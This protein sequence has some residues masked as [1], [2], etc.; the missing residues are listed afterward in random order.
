M[1]IHLWI[2]ENDYQSGFPLHETSQCSS[3]I[4]ADTTTQSSPRFSKLSDNIVNTSLK[5]VYGPPGSGKTTWLI[6][7]MKQ[8]GVPYERIAF[9]SFSRTT[10]KNIKDRLDLTKE[11]S[12]F[13]RTVHSMNFHLL[14]IKKDQVAN[15]HL[16]KFPARFSKEFLDDQKI[17]VEGEETVKSA[18]DTIDDLFYKQ[19][20]SERNQ[21]LPRNYVP[22]QYAKSSGLYL[23]FKRRYFDWLEENDYIDFT[24]M[25]EQGIA[26]EHIPPVDLLCVDEW[27]DLTPLQVKQVTFWSQHI[28]LSVH[29]GDDDQTIHEWA[30][31]KHQ[32]FLEFPT[33]T[34]HEKKTIILNKTYRLPTR[35]LDMSVAFIR[36]NKNRVDKEFNA[37]KDE[38]GLIEITNIDK[39]ADIL[40]TQLRQ[41]TCKVLVRNNSLKIK[42]MKDLTDRGIPVNVILKKAVDAIAFISEKKQRLSI[43][44]LFFIADS[45][46]FHGTKHFLRG[47]KSGLKELANALAAS[48]EHSVLV[49]DLLQY[50]VRGVLVEAIKSGDYTVLHTKDLAKTID[51]YKTYGKDYR[52]VEISSIHTSKGTEADT[53]VVCLDVAKRTYLESRDPAHIEEERRVWYVAMTRT[54]KN[55][56]FL[57][58]TYRGFY[59]SPL[60]D[61]IK[62]YL[63]NETS[64]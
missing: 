9:V 1:Q 35:V 61:Y 43:E 54:K 41:G 20:M 24:G 63:K 15:Q 50:K 48:G 28:P 53:V 52:P 40:K 11:Q 39:V 60:T 16:H 8:S 2:K 34:P 58:P 25:L 55:L 57:E 23:E 32:D 22:I 17:K 47:G 27:Q 10:I 30:G 38:R 45:P 29:A 49:D 62:I 14:K 5:K 4:T 33:F 56:I 51:M 12:Q 7:Y 59:P 46:A 13:F 64:N 37:V 6:E 36:R 19:M 21:L 18:N 26:E 44:D 31:A 3:S 42:V